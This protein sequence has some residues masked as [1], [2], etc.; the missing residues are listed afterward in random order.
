MDNSN[1]NIILNI[2]Q[3]QNHGTFVKP[4]LCN[5]SREFLCWSN[6]NLEYVQ[7]PIRSF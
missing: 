3:I 1:Y 6:R 7:T 4:H 2:T 5:T